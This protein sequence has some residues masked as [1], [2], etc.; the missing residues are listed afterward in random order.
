MCLNFRL[1][2]GLDWNS[3]LVPVSVHSMDSLLNSPP[4]HGFNTNSTSPGVSGRW[5]R[6]RRLSCRWEPREDPSRQV[7]Q[8]VPRY[9]CFPH[10]THPHPTNPIPI[11]LTPSLPHPHPT[12]HI[13]TLSPSLPSLPPSSQY[14]GQPQY[15]GQQ[16]QPQGQGGGYYWG[17]STL[18]RWALVFTHQSQF[19]GFSVPPTFVFFY[20]NLT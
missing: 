18:D 16:Y 2:T 15:G 14:G 17:H 8:Q 13:P 10:I 5:R 12:N 3:Y 19:S 4:S 1:K 9:L 11:L 7:V 6:P 20:L